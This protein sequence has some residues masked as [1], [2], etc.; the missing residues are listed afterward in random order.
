MMR[1]VEINF[2]IN[3]LA[4]RRNLK[5]LVTPDVC[6]ISSDENFRHIPVP[7]FVRLGRPIWIWL[8]VEL[9]LASTCGLALERQLTETTSLPKDM[10]E[11]CATL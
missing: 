8:Q 7:E 6:E 5:F 2:Q 11:A 10:G 4:L 3:P 1:F 9:S